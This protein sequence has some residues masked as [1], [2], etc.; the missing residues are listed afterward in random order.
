MHS[1]TDTL[2]APV[3][4]SSEDLVLQDDVDGENTFVVDLNSSPIP[5]SP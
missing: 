4:D 3:G 2:C 5:P 1:S